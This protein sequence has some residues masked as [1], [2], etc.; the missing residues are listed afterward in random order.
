MITKLSDFKKNKINESSIDIIS[1]Y[2]KKIAKDLD[3]SKQYQYQEIVDKLTK[4]AA[5]PHSSDINS[6]LLELAANGFKVE[7]SDGNLVE[8][9][10]AP[11]K[12]LNKF[13][14]AL[15]P[16]GKEDSDINNDGKTDDHDSYLLNRR[17]KIKKAILAKEGYQFDFEDWDNT[18][19][20][21]MGLE[22]SIDHL[23]EETKTAVEREIDNAVAGTGVNVEEVKKSA[24]TEIRKLWI[25]KINQDLK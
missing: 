3:K 2:A 21:G 7:D 11:S 1:D 14:E 22:M 8:I 17:K 12:S 16:V 6:I 25:D 20:S 5:L 23:I 18:D 24:Y 19:I 13:K 15:D 9:E 10:T 4:F